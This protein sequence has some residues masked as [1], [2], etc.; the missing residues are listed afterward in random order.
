[1]GNEPLGAG[2]GGALAIY[3]FTRSFAA[4]SCSARNRKRPFGTIQQT[5]P[6][7]DWWRA[8]ALGGRRPDRLLG[9]LGASWNIARMVLGL[10]EANNHP[11]GGSV[12]AA[13]VPVLVSPPMGTVCNQILFMI[14]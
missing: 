1:V 4:C 9:S 8:G 14:G 11:T 3:T 7:W 5:R 13:P 10:G 2:G 12:G 6:R